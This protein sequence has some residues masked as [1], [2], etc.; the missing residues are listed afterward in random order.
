[1]R[2]TEDKPGVTNG[3][4]YVQE[5]L[6]FALLQGGDKPRP[7]NVC[8]IPRDVCFVYGNI[9]HFFPGIIGT[10]QVPVMFV[11]FPGNVGAGFIPARFPAS[12]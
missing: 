1:M 9:T 12:I 4:S 6:S 3:F 7:Y 2:Y 11:S 10:N 8:F 5:I